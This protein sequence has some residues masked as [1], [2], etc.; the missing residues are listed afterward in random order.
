MR[1]P[2]EPL[3]VYGRA[4]GMS[5]TR[6]GALTGLS[7]SNWVHARARGLTDHQA[8]LAAVRLGLH[9]AELWPGWFDA[10]LTV[11]DRDYLCG[12]WRQAWLWKERA[13]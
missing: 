10:G 3:V 9:P 13:A 12:G 11:L 8:D 1:W 2:V 7:G 5:I 6:I 4:H